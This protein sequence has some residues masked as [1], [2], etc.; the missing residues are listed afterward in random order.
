MFCGVGS[1]TVLLENQ[2]DQGVPVLWRLCLIFKSEGFCV[3]VLMLWLIG[4][5]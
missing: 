5:F 3:F 2:R 4:G 1:H